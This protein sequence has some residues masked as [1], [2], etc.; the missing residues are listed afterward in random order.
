MLGLTPYLL[1]LVYVEPGLVNVG[2]DTRLQFEL[3]AY[4]V[5]D[6]VDSVKGKPVFNWVTT[7]KES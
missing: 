3:H 2:L 1:V 7:L 6:R 5:A 4:F